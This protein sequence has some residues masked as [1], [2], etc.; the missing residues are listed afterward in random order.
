[1]TKD[2]V[3]PRIRKQSILIFQLVGE[4]GQGVDL[5]F[6]VFCFSSL[7]LLQAGFETPHEIFS[8]PHTH[9]EVEAGHGNEERLYIKPLFIS[10][11]SQRL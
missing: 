7:L 10:G 8:P 9:L 1:M 3:F 2:D 11:S 4:E 6:C 5:T